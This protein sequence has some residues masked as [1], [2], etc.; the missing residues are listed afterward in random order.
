MISMNTHP[1]FRAT[2][3]QKNIINEKT[4]CW[5]VPP[6]LRGR[7]GVIMVAASFFVARLAP[8]LRVEPTGYARF[9]TP[10]Q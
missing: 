4:A 3:F 8:L 9:G 5:P 7:A 6:C 2:I 10:P 1:M